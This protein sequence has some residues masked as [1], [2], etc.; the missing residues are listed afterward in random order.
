[1]T[2]LDEQIKA[3]NKHHYSG[4]DYAYQLEKW[5]TL[6]AAKFVREKECIT[7]EEYLRLVEL[8]NSPDR[9]NYELAK[10]LIITK[11]QQYGK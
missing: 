9:E 3:E 5:N 6:D 10:I 1:M 2:G 7:Q 11:Q 4:A 8:I